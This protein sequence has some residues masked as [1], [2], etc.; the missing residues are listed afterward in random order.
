MIAGGDDA[1][2]ASTALF[3]IGL[4]N[5][6]FVKRYPHLSHSASHLRHQRA[7]VK[8]S[9]VIKLGCTLIAVNNDSLCNVSNAG[10]N[11]CVSFDA[12]YHRSLKKLQRC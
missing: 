6:G 2:N 3:I 7:A 8:H 9:N 11:K 5:D 1:E 4:L 10:L 12:C